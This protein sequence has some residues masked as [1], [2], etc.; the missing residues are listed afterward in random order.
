M[1]PNVP[2]LLP[3]PRNIPSGVLPMRDP[4]RRELF[5]QNRLAL[6]ST[7]LYS[8]AQVLSGRSGESR[9]VV[10]TECELFF[11][12]TRS[13][14]AAEIE[15]ETA[16]EALRTSAPAAPG[17]GGEWNWEQWTGRRES[18]PAP[19]PAEEPAPL[20]APGHLSNSSPGGTLLTENPSPPS[21]ATRVRNSYG[22]KLNGIL[23]GE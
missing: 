20:S 7:L 2:N 4:S 5:L 6:A 19:P 23:S 12:E 22:M 3:P 13:L 1:G 10:L 9:A 21:L 15:A 11:W 14:L 8:C 18:G 17:F 16:A